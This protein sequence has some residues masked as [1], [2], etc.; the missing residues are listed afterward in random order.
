[1]Q[2]DRLE[3][4]QA[5]PVFG[6]V[7]DAHGTGL[8]LTSTTSL[9]LADSYSSVRKDLDR[10]EWSYGATITAVPAEKTTIATTFTQSR[11][12]QDMPYVRTQLPRYAGI[13]AIFSEP[14][15]EPRRVH[16]ESDV[17]SLMIGANHL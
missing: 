2:M 15:S 1:M 12:E 4:L 9:G 6:G 13:G 16:W 3:F 17:K 8:Q 11:D 14:F 10:L 5:M 7:R